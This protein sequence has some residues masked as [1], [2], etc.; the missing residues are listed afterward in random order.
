MNDDVQQSRKAG[1]KI[2]TYFLLFFLVFGS[3]NAY[4]VYKALSSNTGVVAENSYEIG[5]NYNKILEEA[6]KR[7]HDSNNRHT[8]TDTTK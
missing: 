8:T 5:L 7:H 3:V 6:K 1:F 4:F 2:L